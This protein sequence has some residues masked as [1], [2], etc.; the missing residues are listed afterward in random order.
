[1]K[2]LLTIL[3]SI[4][5]VSCG[6]GLTK[7]NLL[8]DEPSSVKDA[9]RIFSEMKQ[10]AENELNLLSE[11]HKKLE[12]NPHYWPEVCIKANDAGMKVTMKV[13]E[14]LNAGSR[15]S[16]WGYRILDDNRI[17]ITTRLNLSNDLERFMNETEYFYEKVSV[18][19]RKSL[20]PDCLKSLRTEGF[21]LF[22]GGKAKCC[23]LIEKK[24][25]AK[26]KKLYCA[27]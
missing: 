16:E 5:L 15:L 26:W 18:L 13:S 22:I 20:M 3:L 12:L 7:S 23:D 25:D 14:Y 27:Q 4:F 6:T 21:I 8:T 9:K 17:N 2:K 19:K 24:M 11:C 1:M 10:L